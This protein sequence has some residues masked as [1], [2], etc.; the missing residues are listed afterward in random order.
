MTDLSKLKFTMPRL[1][2]ILNVTS[3]S[4][5]DG[6]RY[7]D[8]EPAFE[9][10]KQMIAEGADIIDIG[11]ESTRPGSLPVNETIQIER[12]LP[13]VQAIAEEFPLVAISVDTRS[14]AVAQKAVERGATIINDISALRQDAQLAPFIAANPQLKV[15]LMHM[16][17]DPLTMQVNPKYHNVIREVH[18]FFLERLDFC[19]RARI[20]ENQIWLDPGIGFGKNLQHN[21]ILLANLNLFTGMNYPVVL[22][23]SRKRFIND[24]IPSEPEE[25]LPGTLAAAWA[26][27]L[28]NVQIL[29]VHDVAAHKQFLNVF[30]RM[31][32]ETG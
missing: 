25:R 17:G 14:F 22:A 26:G 4:F 1:M 12:L 29:R 19:S 20:A 13:L 10:A 3:D 7:L 15:I 23:A 27:V 16:A 6:G 31:L 11:A 2:G 18:E 28:Q 24:I 8:P 30:S 32:L 5:S 9:H 21:L